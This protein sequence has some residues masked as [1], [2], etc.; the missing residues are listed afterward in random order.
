MKE[1]LPKTGGDQVTIFYVFDCNVDVILGG[2][3]FLCQVRSMSYH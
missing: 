3:V 1:E 2:E